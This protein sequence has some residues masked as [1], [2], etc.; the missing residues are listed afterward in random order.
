MT[1]HVDF[2]ETISYFKEKRYFGGQRNN[3]IFYT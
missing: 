3:F 1:N 2:K